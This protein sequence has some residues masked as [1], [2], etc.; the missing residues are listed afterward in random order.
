MIVRIALSW[1]A[2]LSG[3][4]ET[5]EVSDET[6]FIVVQLF[7]ETRETDVKIPLLSRD[8]NMTIPAARPT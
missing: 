1:S 2:A 8:S 6:G 3:A 5:E 4:A 7:S